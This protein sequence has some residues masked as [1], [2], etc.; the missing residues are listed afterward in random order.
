VFRACHCMTKLVAEEEQARE[1]KMQRDYLDRVYKQN[2]M[3]ESLTRARFS[4]FI[5]RDGT[6]I[7]LRDTLSF[8]NEFKNRKQGI[9][10]YGE[11]GNGKSHLCVSIHHQLTEKGYTSLF[12]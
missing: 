11:P 6:S 5:E 3:N 7:A 1:R 10:L 4:T 9:L 2:L 8:A 12:L